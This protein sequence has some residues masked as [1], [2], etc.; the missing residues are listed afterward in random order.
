MTPTESIRGRQERMKKNLIFTEPLKELADYEAVR[1]KM[2]RV[3]GIIAVSGCVEAQKAEMIA[4]L[5]AGVPVS[6]VVSENDLTARTIYENVRFYDPDA[7][8]YPAKD[9]LFYQA[10]I[11]SNELDRQRMEVFR[12][13]TERESVTVV[14]PVTALMDFVTTRSALGAQLISFAVGDTHD[15]EKVKKELVM[16]GYERCAA[17][18][19]PGQFSFRGDILDIWP[20]TETHPVRIEYFGDEIDGMRIFDP[21]TQRSIENI[22]QITVY[23]A[24]DHTG[25]AAPFISWFGVKDTEVFLDDPNRIS[26]AAHAAVTELAESVKNRAEQGGFDMKSVPQMLTD[27]ELRARL[28]GMHCVAMSTL[29]MRRE[30]WEIAGEY[31]LSVQAVATYNNSV[32]LLADDL[33]RYMKKNYRVIVLSSSPSRARRLAQGLSDMDLP[34][35]FLSMESDPEPLKPG[36]IAVMYG[37]AS[38]GFEYP[39]IRFAVISDSDIFGGKHRKKRRK[40]QEYSGKKISSFSDLSVGDYVVHEDH[41]LG[42]YRGIEKVEVDGALRDYIKIEYSGSN[43]Y[44]LATQLDKLQK[45]AGSEAAKPKLNK[46]GGQEW[47]KTRS[48]VKASVQGIAKELVALYAARGQKNGFVYSPD[49]EWQREF[50]EMFPYEETE[51]QLKAIEDT[52]RDMES[53]KIMDRLI[54]GD[55]GYGKT[56]IALRAAFKAVQDGKQVAVLAPTTILAQQHFNTFTQRMKEFPVRVDLVCRFRTKQQ[57]DRS[58]KDLKN[59]QVDIVIGTHRLLSKD[60]KF[61]DLGLLVVDEEQRFGVKHKERIKQMRNNVDVLTLTATPIPRTLHMSL[62]GIR[63][64]S[65]LEEPPQDRVPIQTY[66]MEFNPEMVREAISREM[67]R[68]GQVYYVYNRVKDIADM[69][70]R[71]QD[72]VPEASVAYADGQMTRERLESVMVDFINGD[73]DVLVTTTI[74]ETGLDIGNVNTMIIHDADKLGLSQLYQLRGR[75]GR[76]NRTAYAFLMYRRD[77][78]LKEVAEK[79]LSAIR[80]F[81]ELGSGFKIAMRDLEIRG[82]G[83][84]LGAE[85]SGHIESVGYDLYCKML[86]E[87]VAEAKGEEPETETETVVDLNISAYIPDRYIPDE[88]QKLD[89]YKRIAGIAD[90]ADLEDIQDELLDRYGD[91]PRAVASLLKIADLKATARRAGITEIKQTGREVR[92]TVG[93]KPG[94]D[95]SQVPVIIGH[96]AGQFTVMAARSGT[97]FIYHGPQDEETMLK[98]L[99]T[100]T[101]ALAETMK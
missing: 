87:A 12:A 82:A 76:T 73:I 66:V 5:S 65:I 75:V 57:I 29:D 94:F 8:L 98:A 74:I 2:R 91:L 99:K 10:D 81:T 62:I 38:R 93:E 13:L 39:Q 11:A 96:Y 32:E 14:M 70:K 41:G 67:A 17:A 19:M 100:F 59:G 25:A 36:Q 20:L 83:S 9:L 37:H 58:L 46:L 49:T 35:V 78:M 86:S 84:L 42:I 34:A 4:G 80:E 21:E 54:C 52:K 3:T 53:T 1:E 89:F 101:A 47:E 50:E 90:E 48:R 30:G 55:V 69:A 88:F 79:R 22:E 33:R 31:A 64:M 45:Y 61:K 95:V 16:L 44:I 18:E 71:I 40:R 77:K 72:L 51:D 92:L 15:F 63:D 7:L 27:N 23:P 56:E 28:S 68:G 60:V 26:D 97:G 6:L 43:L 24:N 85:Q